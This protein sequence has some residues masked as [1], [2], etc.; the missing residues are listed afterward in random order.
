RLTAIVNFVDS[1]MANDAGGIT[2]AEAAADRTQAQSRNLSSNAGESFDQQRVAL[3]YD[4]EISGTQSL[5]LRAY[6]MRKDFQNFLPIGTHIPFVADDGVVEFDRSFSGGGAMYLWDT[7]L[8][9]LPNQFTVG[10]DLD[11]QE[12]DRS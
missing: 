2:R 1:P 11:V 7:A 12:D 5:T 8:F 3:V 6:T 4:K 10:V 9:G